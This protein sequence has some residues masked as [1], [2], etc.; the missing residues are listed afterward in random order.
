MWPSEDSLRFTPLQ[1]NELITRL[2]GSHLLQTWEWGQV[3]A[4]YG[5]KPIGLV[6]HETGADQWRPSRVILKDQESVINESGDYNGYTKWDCGNTFSGNLC[7]SALILLR[8][9]SFGRLATSLRVMYIPKGPLVNWTN[10]PLRRKVIEDIHTFAYQKGAIF[11]KIDPDVRLGIGIPGQPDSQNDPVGQQVQADL[12]ERGW[13]FSPEQIQFRNTVLVDL[14][15]SEAELLQRMKQK[16]R[17]NIRLAE[18]K[19]VT[20][21]PGTLADSSLLYHM[22]AETSLRD[23]FVIRDEDYYRTVWDTFTHSFTSDTANQPGMES[24][25]AEVAGEPVAGVIIYRFGG[26]AWYLSGM[27]VDAHREKMP[28]YLLQWEAIRRAKVA[29]CTVYDLWGAPDEFTETDP[30]WGV[31]RFKEGLG[32]TVVRTLGAWDDP[33]RPTLYRW[34]TIILPRWLDVIRNRGIRRTRKLTL[35]V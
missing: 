18:R 23:G 26:K 15:P 32:G 20:I 29:G 28:N 14:T 9:L 22:Y 3:K 35:G 8:T 13:L 25:I 30:L 19:G 31:Y 1:W 27:S 11:I 4:Q 6:W 2:P 21:R 10:V 5:W 16:T 34:Y 33:I 17:Y 24:L 7:A 12:H